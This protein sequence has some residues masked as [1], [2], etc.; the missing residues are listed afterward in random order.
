ME[1][2]KK[3]FACYCNLI[4]NNMEIMEILIRYLGIKT[5]IILDIK[6]EILYNTNEKEIILD[7][8]AGSNFVAQSLMDSRIVYSN[9]I[10]KYSFSVAKLIMNGLSND[11]KANLNLKNILES[12]YYK[13]NYN[14]LCDLF[15]KP[16]K[17]ESEVLNKVKF[18]DITLPLNVNQDVIDLKNFYENEP[19]TGNF[20]TELKCFSHLESVYT[21][22]YYAAKHER[23]INGYYM[24]FT[25]IYSM[26]YFSL[27]QAVIIDSYRYAIDK[28]LISKEI[29]ETVHNAYLCAMI[30]LLQNIVCSVGDHFAQPQQ[31]KISDEK[32]YKKEI[33]KIISKKNYNVFECLN[34]KIIEISERNYESKENRCF[35]RDC[36]DII[37]D[38]SIMDNVSAVYIDPPYTNAHY[39]RFYHIL[40]TLVEYNYP[41]IK[42]FGRYSED[43]IQSEFCIKSKALNAFEQLI[44]LCREKNKKLFI[45]YSDTTQCIVTKENLLDVCSKYYVDVK[46][47]EVDHMYRN[48]GQ[49]ARRVTG[50]ELIISCR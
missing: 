31:F 11:E 1:K 25:L 28:M 33:V 26:P 10:Q 29:S 46:I 2:E 19:Y 34:N 37:T 50:K 43:R 24:L 14:F 15:Y 9:D 47:K 7:L 12:K 39:S 6:N 49:K 3:Q 5:K 4:K 27:N 17:E 30:Y 36:F 42:H 45:S 23:G 22:E 13:E 21:N 32:K 16:L 20:K 18:L 35:N 38:D 44:N 8:F 41:E 48:F 40:E